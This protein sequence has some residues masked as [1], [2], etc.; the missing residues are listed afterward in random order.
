MIAIREEIRAIE[1]GR[2][3]REDNPL[4]N[5]PHTAA[6]VS[7]D[8]WT[9]SYPRQQAAYP[10]SAQLEH[11]YWPPVGRIDNARGDRQLVCLRIDEAKG[12]V[13]CP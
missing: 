11:K 10:T 2:L 6:H 12:Q 7:S 13:D 9:H 8:S 5:A 1:E 3:D 4:R